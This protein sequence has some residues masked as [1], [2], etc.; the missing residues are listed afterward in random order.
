MTD[1]Q[2]REPTIFIFSSPNCFVATVPFGNQG[3]WIWHHR[4][5]Q[6]AQPQFQLRIVELMFG[7]DAEPK[8]AV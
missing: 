8:T 7:C 6:T 4:L 5:A 3:L 1:T 2:A